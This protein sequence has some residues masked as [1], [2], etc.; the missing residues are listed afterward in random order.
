ML[1]VHIH[2]WPAEVQFRKVPPVWHDNQ[3][4]GKAPQ[5]FVDPLLSSDP[6][7]LWHCGD[8]SEHWGGFKQERKGGNELEAEAP[9]GNIRMLLINQNMQRFDTSLSFRVFCFLLGSIFAFGTVSVLRDMIYSRT[10]VWKIVDGQLVDADEGETLVRASNNGGVY[11]YHPEA[12]Y[13]YSVDGKTFNGE[14]L[15]QDSGRIVS[16]SEA[17]ALIT[18]LQQQKSVKVYYDTRNPGNSYLVPSGAQNY[19]FP[20]MLGIFGATIG[21]FF[22]IRGKP[23][24]SRI[25]T[26]K[27]ST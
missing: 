22:A 3:S 10:V 4:L 18:E 8:Y 27:P 6:L 19:G 25:Y 15:F 14:D 11:E 1:C 12:T 5:P 17:E 24:V 13:S 23:F 26:F 2:T 21:G 16:K 9:A 20:I 7:R